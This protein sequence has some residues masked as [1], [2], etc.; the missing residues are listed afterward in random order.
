MKEQKRLLHKAKSIPTIFPDEA[1]VQSNAFKVT[2]TPIPE[3]QETKPEPKKQNP[4]KSYDRD[5]EEIP[6]LIKQGQ[7]TSKEMKQVGNNYKQTASML[8]K[9]I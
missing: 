7:S 4:V 3:E 2:M 5:K 6:N 1:L 9:F 8:K